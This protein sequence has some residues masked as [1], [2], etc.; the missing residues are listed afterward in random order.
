M[1]PDPTL[2]AILKMMI[3]ND[4]GVDEVISAGYDEATVRKVWQLL[5]RAEFKRKQGAQGI[6]LSRRSFDEDWD[7]PITKK[8]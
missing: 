6:R 2:D 4:A 5:H 8:V 1:P 3:E 7:Y